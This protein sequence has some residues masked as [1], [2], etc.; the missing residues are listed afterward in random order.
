MDLNSAFG[1]A[2]KR[3]RNSLGYSQETLALLCNLDRTY[4]GLLE[5]GKRN[6]S[7]KSI[8]TLSHHL[9]TTPSILIKEVEVILSKSR[10]NKGNV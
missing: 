4:I 1:E 3:K 2:I 6:P 5:R 9:N 10:G 7:L 8:F